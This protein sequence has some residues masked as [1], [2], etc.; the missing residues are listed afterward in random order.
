MDNLAECLDQVVE[1]RERFQVKDK[2]TAIWAVRKIKHLRDQQNENR[3]LAAEEID[4]I[5]AWEKGENDKLQGDIDFF[6]NLLKDY[7][8]MVLDA[9]PKAKTIKLPHGQ[10][11]LRAQQ[12]AFEKNNDKLLA[13]IKKNGLSLIRVKE[14]ADWGELKKQVDVTDDGTVIYKDTGEVV[15]GVTAEVRPPKFSVKTD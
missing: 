13:W 15:D 11:Q 6:E 2:E 4:R 10:L 7:H 5:Q 3:I 9:D 1:E 8:Y 12:P 14:E